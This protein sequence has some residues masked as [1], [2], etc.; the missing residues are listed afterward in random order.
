[1]EQVRSV[2][3]LLQLRRRWALREPGSAAREL[4]ETVTGR[5]RFSGRMVGGHA[6]VAEAVRAGWADAGIGIRLV[7][8]EAG[9]G[10]VPLRTELL[11]FCIPEPL[12]RD[13]RGKALIRLLGSR[14]Q[15]R[16]IGQLPGYDARE[17]GQVQSV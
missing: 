16:L 11:D 13:P 7:A 4:L 1:D 12:T 17:T 14:T 3:K 15:R 6:S 10:F 8:A 5:R 2:D 9:T